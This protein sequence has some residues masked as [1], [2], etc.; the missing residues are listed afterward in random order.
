MSRSEATVL[1]TVAEGA[2]RITE[3]AALEGLAQPTITVLVNR[4]EGQGLVA[5]ERDRKDAR[6][7]KVRITKVGVRALEDLRV[8]YRAALR[9]ELASMADEQVA[10]LMG[11]C[12]ALETL[13]EA[14]QEGDDR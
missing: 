7:V 14:F 11:A 5:R 1:S 4:L 10:A 13:A 8:R 2:R 6:V 3:L 9:A 12:R